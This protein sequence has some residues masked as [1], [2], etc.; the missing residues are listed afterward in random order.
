MGVKSATPENKKD[1]WNTQWSTVRDAEA[2]IGQRFTLDACAKD[3]GAAKAREWI[4][5]EQD[6]LKTPWISG[7]GAVWCNPPFTMKLEFLERAHHQAKLYGRIVVC[8][9]PQEPSTGWWQRY[10]VGKAT[11]VFMPDG[12]YNFLDDATKL[13]APGCN[14]CSCFV[15]FT[16]LNVP[17]QYVHF[18]RGIGS[19]PANDN[20]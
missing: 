17:T 15:V 1:F 18:V 3:A 14:F 16:P 20:A 2:L 10:V 4:T 6:A 5:P 9:I 7:N 13:L 11:F 19:L 12:R 8:M